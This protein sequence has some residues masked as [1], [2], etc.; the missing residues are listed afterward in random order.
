[1]LI[2]TLL[3][4]HYLNFNPIP[5]IPL[6]SS[7]I[8]YFVGGK[9]GSP[10]TTLGNRLLWRP[11]LQGVRRRRSF[12]SISAFCDC[13]VVGTCLSLCVRVCVCACDLIKM[14]VSPSHMSTVGS[15]VGFLSCEEAEA[16]AGATIATPAVP[17][18]AIV[19][20]MEL[21]RPVKYEELQKEAMMS[22][23]P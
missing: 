11:H 12:H 16:E 18:T 1:M 13:A 8:K 21:P 4:I 23:K 20:Y 7:S 15:P 3:P 9:D 2:H 5:P 22:L 19:D 6:F 17:T 14:G 10:G